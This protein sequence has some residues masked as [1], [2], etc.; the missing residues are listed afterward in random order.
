MSPWE[1]GRRRCVIESVE[2][3][4]EGGRFPIKRTVGEAVVVEADIFVDGHDLLDAVVLYRHAEDEVWREAW[5]QSRLND[6]WRGEFRVERCGSYRYTLQA[7]VDHFASWRRDFLKRQAAG[8]DLG[9]PLQSGACLVVEA[10]RRARGEAARQLRDWAGRLGEENDLQQRAVWALDSGLLELMRRHADRSM[11]ITYEPELRVSVDRTLARFSAWYELFPRSTGAQPHQH[12]SFRDCAERLDYVAAMGFDILYLPPIHPIGLSQRKGPNNRLDASPEDPGSPWAIGAADGGHTETHRE[13][14][15]LEDFRYLREQAAGRG[16]ELALDIAF[17]CSPDHPWVREHPEWFYRR[18]DGSIQFAEN[19]PKQYQDIYPLNF[20]SEDWQGLWLAL[21]EVFLF[22][23]EQGVKV[24]RVDNPHTKSLHFWEWVIGEVK[25]RE[26]QAIFLAEAFTR[27]RLLH[28]LAKAG[29]SQSY[30]Y[31]PWRNTKWELTQYLSELTQRAGREYLRPNLWPNTP[32]I[33]PEYLQIGGRPAFVVRLVL[34]ATLGAN[35]GIYGPAFELLEHEPREPGSEEYLDS[36][37]YQLRQWDL[38]RRDSLRDLIGRI[39][40]IRRANPALQS[41]WSLQ[42]H[43]IDNDQ[44]IA[45]SKQAP[46][47]ESAVLVVV[48]LDPHHRQQG[49]VELPLERFGM[50]PQQ[51]YQMHDLLGGARYLW[52][53]PRNYVELDPQVVSAHIFRLRRRLRTEHDFDYYF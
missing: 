53:G 24:F 31:F 32:D 34:A 20:E 14:G 18:P 21:R 43:P 6:R 49:W 46:D 35:Y 19:P 52:S 11:A 8:Q 27:P 2:P 22:W 4:I 15:D 48:N 47:G 40:R 9:L 37:K 30:N 25:Q 1:Q 44:L 17:Q 13:L 5:L 16:I 50:H 26:P 28:R 39:N 51:P 38:Q 33:L 3:Q 41:D 10:A 12:G 23:L 42:F 29:F 45:Y 7:W 36:E